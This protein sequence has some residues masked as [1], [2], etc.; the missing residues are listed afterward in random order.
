[1][2][3]RQ[4]QASLGSDFVSVLVMRR[5]EKSHPL[6]EI[7]DLEGRYVLFEEKVTKENFRNPRPTACGRAG[8]IT[9]VDMLP[10]AY[11]NFGAGDDSKIFGID[12][13]APKLNARLSR[14]PTCR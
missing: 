7:L 3:C 6:K 12:V 5:F 1:M 9:L 4:S 8:G 2:K 10:P 11:L 13:L 14:P